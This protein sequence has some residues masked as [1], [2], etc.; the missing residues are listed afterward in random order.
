MKRLFLRGSLFLTSLALITSTLRAALPESVRDWVEGQA[1]IKTLSAAFRQERVL[2]SLKKP[3]ANE[4]HLWFAAPG[5]FRWELTAP[6]SLLVVQ[7]EP[8]HLLLLDPTRHLGRRLSPEK[9]AQGPADAVAF[10][11]MGFPRKPEEFEKAF[12]ILDS[13][14]DGKGRLTS[15]SLQLRDAKAAAMVPKIVFNMEAST[16]TL[17]AF[18][19]FLK[20]GSR[21]DT[22]I[23]SSKRNE[24]IK[25]DVF[26]PDLTQYRIKD[27]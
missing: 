2:R 17:T 21:I 24:A 9:A 14:A 7:A 11:Q 27:E 3:L 16:G 15:L 19:V 1:R 20:D 23:L 26:Q 22:T 13:T 10:L 5:R 4:G 12:S 8:T 25:D 18:H 6:S